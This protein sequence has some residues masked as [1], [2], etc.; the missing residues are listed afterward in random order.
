MTPDQLTQARTVIRAVHTRLTARIAGAERPGL[1]VV[2]LDADDGLGPVTADPG[3]RQQLDD[4]CRPGRTEN[5]IVHVTER[6]S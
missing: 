6:K 1:C 5:I 2:M 3:T 4:L